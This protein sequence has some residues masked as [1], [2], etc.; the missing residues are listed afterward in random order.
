M[1]RKIVSPEQYFASL[2]GYNSLDVGASW[3]NSP[4]EQ[5][6]H[7]KG[8]PYAAANAIAQKAAQIPLR[9]YFESMDADGEP[10]SRELKRNHPLPQLFRRVN[11]LDTKW[12]LIYKTI[13]HLDLTG[14]A[15]WFLAAD[16][17]DAVREIWTL[18]P[19]RMKVLPNPQ[20]VVGGYEY[21]NGSEKLTFSPDEVIHFKYPNPSDDWYGYSPLQAAADSVDADEDQKRARRMSYQRGMFPGMVMRYKGS[22]MSDEQVENIRRRVERKFQ[23]TGNAGRILILNDDWG[24]IAPM[25]GWKPQEMGY[26]QTARIGRDEILSMFGVPASVAGLSEDVNRAVAEEMTFTFIE[27]V[28]APK[29]ALVADYLNQSLMPRFDERIVAEFDIP[30]LMNRDAERAD[31]EMYLR[32]GAKT[33][34]E[35]RDE[36]GLKP[37]S[38]GDRPWMSF[39]SAQVGSAMPDEGEEPE[40]SARPA[41]AKGAPRSDA[42]RL[43]AR[44]F[45][46]AAEGTLLKKTA[47]PRLLLSL[48]KGATREMRRAGKDPMAF[49]IHDPRVEKFLKAKGDKIAEDIGETTKAALKDSLAAGLAEGE[50]VDKLARRVATEVYG[51]DVIDRRGMAIART[52]TGASYEYGAQEARTQVGAEKKQWIT[53]GDERVRSGHA[54]ADGQTVENEEPFLVAAEAGGHREKLLHPNDMNGSA[55]NVVN[56]RCDVVGIY[57]KGYEAEERYQMAA[58]HDKALQ[59]L[60]SPFQRAMRTY[61]VGQ[62]TRVLKRLEE[63]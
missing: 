47:S 30:R 39:G 28:V 9:F 11:S 19:D 15:Y 4:A 54:A 12:T 23:G 61:F 62:K 17:L 21:R 33:I 48:R 31:N 57:A 53:S 60:E 27:N 37:V 20:R 32:T 41:M 8:W 25:T 58:L 22:E 7:F 50:S 10:T 56:C 14:N 46:G 2:V 51:E 29:L 44:I 16:K 40:V 63:E 26:L 43:A 36:I 34:N 6:A 55:G 45:A 18:R 3:S 38:W 35:V 1:V 42:A 52:E 49:D 13:C 24:E 5:L 59:R